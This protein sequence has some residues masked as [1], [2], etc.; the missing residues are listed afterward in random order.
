MNTR[1]QNNG[2]ANWKFELLDAVNDDKRLSHAAKAVMIVF[3]HYASDDNQQR[4]FAG[5]DT[6]VERANVAKHTAIKCR[7]LLISTGYLVPTGKKTELGA[8]VFRLANV[9]P[10]PTRWATKLQRQGVH[11]VHPLND[12]G[13]AITPDKGVQFSQKRGAATAPELD[14]E[15]DR[16]S[17]RMRA[18]T[19]FPL[20]K[21]S[22]S[23]SAEEEEEKREREAEQRWA[24][25]KARKIAQREKRREEQRAKF[26]RDWQQAKA[27]VHADIEN[28]PADERCPGA[29]DE[30]ELIVAELRKPG[31][32][33]KRYR[34]IAVAERSAP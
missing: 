27:R 1:K 6:I 21:K 24:E 25:Q 4:A 2:S 23:L 34:E 26:H 22:A 32:G 15:L 14:R 33:L 12:S 17:L 18:K 3:L 9:N 28:L 5:I 19:D 30:S 29:I 8:N 11:P 10:N 20:E 16:D 31:D 7:D 13:G